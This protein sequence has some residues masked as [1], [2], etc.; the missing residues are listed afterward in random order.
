LGLIAGTVDA[1]GGGG[2][3]P[4][5]A[6]TLLSSGRM[7][8]RKVVGTVDTSEFIVSVCAS[9]GFLLSL[10]LAEIPWRI[11]TA[12]L[13]GGVIAAPIA[14]WI[15]RHLDARI[16]GTAVG[17]WIILTNANTFLEAVGLSGSINIP[18]Y[19]A[20]IIVWI[21]ALYFAVSS[22]VCERRQVFSTKVVSEG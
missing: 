15:V 6:S 2:W 18:L 22:V 5:G 10:S 19:A 9:I 11:V 21:T 14:A 20:A 3:G 8:P 13:V 1:L 16:L 4:I 17:G 7:E 12:L